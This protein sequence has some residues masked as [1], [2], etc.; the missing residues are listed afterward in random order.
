MI[1]RAI[2]T[3]LALGI[4]TLALALASG[5]AN[6]DCDVMTGGGFI[7]V[8]SNN[9]PAKANFGVA[10]G[11]KG[12]SPTFGHLE[13]IDHGSGLNA[14]GTRITAYAFQASGFDSKRRPIRVRG[15]CGTPRT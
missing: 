3:R 14:H 4:A 6:A 8:N 13:H 12:G 1:M 11:S 2:W 7:I 10:G 15:I 5:A 9:G